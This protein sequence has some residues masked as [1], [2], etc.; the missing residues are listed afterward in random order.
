[1]DGR[2]EKKYFASAVIPTIST[3]AKENGAIPR[4]NP[5]KFIG[6]HWAALFP[7]ACTQNVANL[8]IIYR[9]QCGENNP[10]KEYVHL[11]VHIV[12]AH[13]LAVLVVGQDDLT[14]FDVV[15]FYPTHRTS[16]VQ[17]NE[18]MWVIFKG[19]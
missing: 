9:N 15:K 16:L 11:L 3:D 6:K 2:L 10:I 4:Q 8:P 12:L 13:M 5:I 7:L 1:M 17:G 14:I 18:I 19:V